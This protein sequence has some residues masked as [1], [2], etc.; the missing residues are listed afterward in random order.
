MKDTTSKMEHAMGVVHQLAACSKTNDK[1]Q[2]IQLNLMANPAFGEVLS[3]ALDP[4]RVYG[5]QSVTFRLPEAPAEGFGGWNVTKAVLHKLSNREW[6]GDEAKQGVI[7]LMTKMSSSERTLFTRILCK[8]L[9]C[10]VGATLVNSVQAGLVP[11]FGIMLA[12]PLEPQHLKKLQKQ[13]H[14]YFQDKKNG[15]RCPVLLGDAPAAYTRNGHQQLNYNHIVDAW[16]GACH[17]FGV[18]L[19]ADGEVIRGDF[20]GTRATKKK[21][22]NNAD[23]AVL[24][25]FDC[26][27][28]EEWTLGDTARYSERR[29]LLKELFKC[30][31]DGAPL[32]RVPSMRVK[33]A[34]ITWEYLEATRD[35]LMAEGEEGLIIRLDEPYNFSTRSSL[36]KFKKMEEGDFVILEI[37]EGEAGKK[38]EGMGAKILVELDNGDSCEVGLKGDM[39]FRRKLWKHRNKYVGMVAEVHY[40]EL[41]KNAQGTQKLQFGVMQR[42]R[43]DKS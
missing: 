12:T 38:Y 26:V 14:V 32:I 41:T 9:R 7:A 10:G 33:G 1:R 39:D 30:V 4:Y 35:A 16:G 24:F 15:D 8:D 27:T 28:M 37:L 5:F 31:P 36:F 22:G 19:A 20:W 29:K 17:E 23:D 25:C 43:G 11:S 40:Q 42:I 3:Y 6:T 18:D 13:E 2:I 21:A 34:G